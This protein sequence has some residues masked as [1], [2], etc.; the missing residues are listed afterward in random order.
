MRGK[1]GMK[2]KSIQQL[3]SHK[4]YLLPPPQKGHSP[5]KDSSPRSFG[6]KPACMASLISFCKAPPPRSQGSSMA[7]DLVI[8]EPQFKSECDCHQTQ[9]LS[10]LL[11]LSHHNHSHR[12]PQSWAHRLGCDSPQ[13]SSTFVCLFF[14]EIKF[15]E[16]TWADNIIYIYVYKKS[17]FLCYHIFDSLHPFCLSPT[18]FPSGEHHP[19]IYICSF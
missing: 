19:A 12:Q 9:P 16:G 5:E 18:H 10:L 15:I 4:A 14:Q 7:E 2:I 6:G 13:T 17:S 1:Q 3:L 11:C 8:A